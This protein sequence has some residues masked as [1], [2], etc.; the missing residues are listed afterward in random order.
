M[1]EQICGTCKWHKYSEG[2]WICDCDRSDSW[3]DWT[4]FEDCCPE[5]EERD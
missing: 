5:W 2:D 1:T 3:G 4:E